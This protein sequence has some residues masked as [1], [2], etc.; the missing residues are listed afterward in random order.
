[1]KPLT[2]RPLFAVRG[3]IADL[4]GRDRS[5][6]LDRGVTADPTL[7]DRVS[8]IL[9]RVWEDRD[10]ALRSLAR[11]LDG[12][13]LDELEVPPETCARA[14]AAL[15][16]AIRLVLQRAAD[17]ITRVHRAIPVTATETEPEPGI[18]IGRRPD[19]LARVGV[20]APGGRRLIRAPCSW[21]SSPRASLAC[22][23]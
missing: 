6:L 16:P 5:V 14:L 10:A 11:E 3:A 2:R 8:A 23:R 19:P 1:M 7:R 22:V 9:A 18:I 20:Y 13:D 21:A 12:V 4:D 15:D 17:N